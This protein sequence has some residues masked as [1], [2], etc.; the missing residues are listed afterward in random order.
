MESRHTTTAAASSGPP[1]GSRAPV[2]RTPLARVARTQQRLGRHARPEQALAGDELALG[3]GHARAAVGHLAR[4]D[5]AAGPT[6]MTIA[7]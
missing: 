2:R 1:I 6:R 3:D 7:S 4:P 5:L